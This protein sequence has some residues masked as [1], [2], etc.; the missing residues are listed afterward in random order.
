MTC[1]SGS[2]KEERPIE[3]PAFRHNVR[4]VA[5]IVAKDLP[6]YVYALAKGGSAYLRVRN[7]A[8]RITAPP[9]GGEGYRCE[10][11]WTSDLH[12]PRVLP[13]LGRWL[14]RR[15]LH[16][17]AVDFSASPE[18]VGRPPDVTFIIGHRGTER[19]RLLELTL[20]SIAAQREASVEAVVVEQARVHS[21]V[22]LPPWVRHVVTPTA[23]EAP[24][25][26]A[27]AFNVGARTATG[28]VIVLHDGD[29]LAPADY[30]SRILAHVRAG[31]EVIEL[32]RFIFY[33]SEPD[34][35]A[36]HHSRQLSELTPTR[37]MQNALGGG[38]LAI[39]AA[40]YARLGGMDEGFSGWGGEDS[41][42]WERCSLLPRWDYTYLPF[43]HLWHP[44]QP[45]KDRRD[46]PTADRYRRL[47]ELPPADRVMRLA[48]APRG[49]PR[50]RVEDPFANVRSGG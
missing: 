28:S 29:L 6:R 36:L 45:Q 38:S 48:A 49:G 14:L 11:R 31:S 1:P 12:A 42:F 23:E 39:T 7:R 20:N 33:L 10:Q 40:A 19:R 8:E 22:A 17:H 37:I 21:E 18:Q 4:S 3:P 25:N 44:D 2:G 26:R 43:V 35:E 32:K 46:N 34:T 15:A 47:A 41:E 16:D 27:W 13:S 9:C 24:Y 30:A 5:G 50:P